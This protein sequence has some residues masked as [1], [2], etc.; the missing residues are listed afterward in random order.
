[1]PRSMVFLCSPVSAPCSG[2]AL[3]LSLTLFLLVAF[4]EVFSIP[5]LGSMV[6]LDPLFFRDWLL[7]RV[8][9][10]HARLFDFLGSR[11]LPSHHAFVLLRSSVLP[12]MSFL[13]RVV[14]PGVLEPAASWF[15][16]KVTG[17][18]ADRLFSGPLSSD[19]AL[20]V[21]LPVASG[22][23]GLRPVCRSSP[24]AYFA[25]ACC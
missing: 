6:S 11:D 21:S 25:S 22:G 14:P 4:R 3:H 7:H 23:F 24:A 9:K 19:L 16:S 18:F 17:I 1:M 20:R 12:R 10:A 13:S 2:P 8:S 15:D 5:V